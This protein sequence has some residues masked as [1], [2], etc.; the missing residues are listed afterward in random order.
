MAKE[1]IKVLKTQDVREGDKVACFDW[2]NRIRVGVLKNKMLERKDGD[3][4]Q[5]FKIIG[6]VIKGR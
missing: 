1:K 6:K 5:V 4:L 2:K 3:C